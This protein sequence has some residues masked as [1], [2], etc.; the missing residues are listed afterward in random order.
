[1][2]K[3]ISV[4][5]SIFI[6]VLILSSCS[7]K[8][9]QEELNENSTA[10]ASTSTEPQEL[11]IGFGIDIEG[12]NPKDCYET[13]HSMLSIVYDTL[14]TYD[15]GKIRPNLAE[16]WT[17]NEDKTEYTFKLKEGVQFSD[18]SPFNAEAVKKNLMAVIKN[19]KYWWLAVNA[20]FKDIEIIDAYQLK[21]TMKKSSP[22]VLS[23]LLPYCPV[24]IVAPSTI[25]SF[26]PVTIEGSVGTGP[27]KLSDYEVNKYY[28]FVKNDYYWGGE[29]EWDKVTLKII[30]DTD[31][32]ILALVSGE[33]DMIMGSTFLSFDAINAME[34][35]D[36][37]TSKISETIVDTRNI[38]IN[39][40]SAILRDARIRKAIAY[41]INREEICATIFS[42]YE[43]ISDAWL[44]KD[45]QYC[46][47]G[48][49]PYTY[50][51]EKAKQ[52]LDAAGWL[53]VAGS[54]YRQKDGQELKIEF[55]W[56]A[57]YQTDK[58]LGHAVKG[59]LSEIGIRVNDQSAELHTWASN[60]YEGKYD[61]VIVDMTPI[62]YQPF[63]S[64][65]A[66]G[67]EEGDGQFISGLTGKNT[68][69]KSIETISAS[70]NDE[71]IAKAFEHIIT[72]V[73]DE[74]SIISIA[75]KKEVVLYNN[76]RIK[77]VKFA[78][79]PDMISPDNIK[80]K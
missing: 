28:T 56:I 66:L 74:A 19:P 40:N 64:I 63:I 33:I 65:S 37:Y 44:I 34:D 68:L 25:T 43:D 2:K 55:G 78:N 73:H 10:K 58:E 61:M 70:G 14:V 80:S 45:L 48:L 8:P 9:T 72:T 29:Q 18:G 69:K 31:A 7:N 71:E 6:L 53:E 47:V 4:L 36:Q 52:L 49:T 75:T 59:Y 20:E 39:T 54:Q 46:D 17:I 77:N 76:E 22:A 21:L 51:I 13:K 42:G 62:P 24:G 60:F 32:R 27:Y 5:L 67:S 50:N 26:D 1:M 23:N 57:D 35:N 12:V 16:S 79:L 11:V 30:P 41:A 38:K 15:K 3:N